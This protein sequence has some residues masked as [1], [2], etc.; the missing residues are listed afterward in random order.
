MKEREKMIL[1]AMQ[2]GFPLLDPDLDPDPNSN[3]RTDGNASSLPSFPP[4]GYFRM[5]GKDI[6]SR[7]NGL[8]AAGRVV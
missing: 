6:D 7:M 3:P 2:L 1:T 8:G 5:G 4:L